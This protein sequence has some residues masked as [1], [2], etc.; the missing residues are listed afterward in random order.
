[1]WDLKIYY[2]GPGLK[3]IIIPLFPPFNTAPCHLN[4][5]CVC[6]ALVKMYDQV[7]DIINQLK[8]PSKEKSVLVCTISLNATKVLLPLPLFP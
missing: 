1:M 7:Q 2:C 8:Q 4:E 5:T 6:C 3:G